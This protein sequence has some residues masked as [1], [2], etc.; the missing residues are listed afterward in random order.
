MSISN[1][2]RRLGEVGETDDNIWFIVDDGGDVRLNS[3]FLNLSLRSILLAMS[4]TFIVA[5]TD[6]VVFSFLLSESRSFSNLLANIVMAVILGFSG[7]VI[8]KVAVIFV[9]PF[10]PASSSL[11]ILLLIDFLSGELIV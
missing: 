8:V 3:V 6:V 11:S 5:V 7:G 1:S 4:G 9:S 10:P 2:D